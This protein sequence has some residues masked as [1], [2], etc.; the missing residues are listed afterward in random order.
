MPVLVARA[1]KERGST[2]DGAKLAAVDDGA[3]LLVAAAEER[4]GRRADA[5]AGL[6]GG[7][8]QLLAFGES[9]PER[10]FAV[11]VLAGGDRPEADFCMG[12][13]DGE[14]DDDVDSGV[15]EQIVDRFGLDAELGGLLGRDLGPHVG[16]AADVEDGEVLHGLE[17]L[18]RDIAGAD[19]ADAQTLPC[20]H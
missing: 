7:G 10:L 9:H 19:D 12:A 11:D 13:R 18:A 20:G 14:V 1:G 5:H 6:V 17:I 4:V 3:R 2:D 8:D 16:D 15:A